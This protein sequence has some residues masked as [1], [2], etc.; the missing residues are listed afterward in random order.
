MLGK[1]KV[2]ALGTFALACL[3]IQAQDKQLFV[4]YY[5]ENKTEASQKFDL[6][7]GI[8]NDLRSQ[9]WQ[10]DV[11]ST[12]V[13]KR[14]GII[15]YVVE[16]TL[17]SE[18]ANQVALGVNFEFKDWS[19]ENFVLVPSIVYNGNRFDKKVMNYPPYWYDKNEWRLDM[20]T[21]TTL[22]PSLEKYENHGKI[23]LTVGNASTPLMAFYAPEQQE[24][25]MVQCH[26]GNRLGDFGLFI[27]EN[28]IKEQA[29]FSIMSPCVREKRAHGTGFT[30]SEDRA[31]DLKKG[32][33]V[34]L[35]F[36]VYKQKAH[37]LQDMYACFLQKP[38]D[39]QSF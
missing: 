5:S 9:Q 17:L 30:D 8:I 29:V 24:S 10:I 13:D 34:R 27:E 31:A 2:L 33:V 35:E 28:K 18:A 15:D 19:A 7:D 12:I 1:L 3:S 22:V 20:P 37:S 4:N 23:E 21:T 16:C 32:D 38:E 11:D 25:W 36:R 26:Q 39:Y 6:R 14:Q